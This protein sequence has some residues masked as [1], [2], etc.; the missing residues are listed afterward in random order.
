MYGQDVELG[1]CF[2]NS[3]GTANI[4][5]L[6]FMEVIDE[7]LTPI[8]EELISN[9]L[10]GVFD[11]ADSREGKNMVEAD[12]SIEAHVIPLG[13]LL[14]TVLDDPTTTFATSLATH[15]Y[16][17]NASDFD[18]FAALRPFT[19]LV[20]LNDGGSAHQ[21]SDLCG[22]ALELNVANGELLTAKLSVIGGKYAQT[23]GVAGSFPSGNPLDWAVGSVS[24]DGSATCKIQDM[25]LTIDNALEARFDICN[26]KTPTRIKRSG[27][28]TVKLSGTME[29]D[30]QT[31][32][33]KFLAGSEQA[34]TAAF[35]TG[36]Q[37][38][39]I[40]IPRLRYTDFPIPVGGPGQ[41]TVGF[42]GKAQYHSNSGTSVQITLANTQSAYTP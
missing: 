38:L 35:K 28:R 9:G 33:Q 5:S 10:R 13:V 6:H 18:E 25:V 1:I 30:D 11:E 42:T 40:D 31:E 27:Y 34:F 3:Y 14:S 39:T 22:N 21:Y 17:P 12:I 15:V 36:S 37:Q 19:A 8:R 32:F 24:L 23:A 20:D 29:F 4:S 16:E 2:Q 41:L 7:G 26:A